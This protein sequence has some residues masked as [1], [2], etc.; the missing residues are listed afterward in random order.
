[1]KYIAEISVIYVLLSY[2][3]VSRR[4]PV[5][6]FTSGCKTNKITVSRNVSRNILLM[7]KQKKTY[8]DMAGYEKSHNTMK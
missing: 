7:H 8:R 3:A 4:I 2:P 5:F 6:R 1:E